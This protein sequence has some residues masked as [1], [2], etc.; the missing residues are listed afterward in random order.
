M[1][2]PTAG[3]GEQRAAAVPLRDPHASAPVPHDPA[4]ADVRRVASALLKEFDRLMWMVT[5]RVWETVPSYSA[6]LVEREELANR[7]RDNV[8]NMLLCLLEN[9]SPSPDEL[10]RS[11]HAGERRALQGVT[12]ISILQS[13][14]TAERVLND[15]YQSWCDRMQVRDSSAR[16]GRDAMVSALDALE[17]AML[18]AFTA[19]DDQIKNSRLLT[20]PTLFQRLAD[21][22][23]IEPE[24]VEELARVL[25]LEDA[26]ESPFVAVAATVPPGDAVALERLRHR[27]LTQLTVAL[28]S[29]GLSGT[30]SL[31]GDDTSGGQLSV[32]LALPWAGSSAELT[33][34][35]ANALTETGI[36]GARAVVGEPRTGLTQLSVPAKRV[37]T[38]LSVT[39]D[40]TDEERVVRY[41]DRLVEV[42]A[43]SDTG[44]A[45]ALIA[46]Y[47]TPLLGSGLEE[48]L[49]AHLSS[50]LSLSATAAALYVH[51]NTVVYRLRRIQEL[52]GLDL[53][54]PRDIARA[55]LALDAADAAAASWSEAQ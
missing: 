40:S 14:R 7:I 19:M 2:E 17:H 16:I 49:R 41:L 43:I 52:T 9:R 13:F 5:E 27:L 54:R 26:E 37:L 47:V 29:P 12:H 32:L 33:P 23:A 10:L 30:V 44:L 48:T 53:H 8:R 15:E 45:R 18:E 3:S 28:G 21:G 38:A 55:V 31:H 35:I 6:Q 42:L 20:E 25:G 51:K 34:L 50:D 4:R 24:E 22:T 11:A 39:G 46:R 1:I 36:E